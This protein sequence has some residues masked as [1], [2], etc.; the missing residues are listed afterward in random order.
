L[1]NWVKNILKRS[2]LGI[3]T[4]HIKKESPS[5]IGKRISGEIDGV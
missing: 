4:K 2:S 1:S 5:D 3:K